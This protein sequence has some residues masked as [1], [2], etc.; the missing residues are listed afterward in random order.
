MFDE[1]DWCGQEQKLTHVSV[2]VYLKR[3]AI[4]RSY[5]SSLVRAILVS[6]SFAI[7]RGSVVHHLVR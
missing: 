3:Y 5:R 1:V 6:A 7:L 4:D 2:W